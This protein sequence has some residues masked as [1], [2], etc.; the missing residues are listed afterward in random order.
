MLETDSPYLTPNS[1]IKG[2]VNT[3]HRIGKVATLVSQVRQE[4]LSQVLK[5]CFICGD[6]IFKTG[7]SEEESKWPFPVSEGMTHSG[8]AVMSYDITAVMSCDITA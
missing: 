8:Y 2:W 4:L 7:K 3:P 1:Y 6:C 5:A